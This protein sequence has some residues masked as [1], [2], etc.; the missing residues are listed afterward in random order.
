M[1]RGLLGG[2]D[3]EPQ[4]LF[5]ALQ[6]GVMNP[7]FLSGAALLSGE[8]M[9]GAFNGMRMGAAFEDQRRQRQLLLHHIHG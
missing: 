8:G 1:A 9:G 6:Q 7:L 5:G 4:G 2:Y 3:D